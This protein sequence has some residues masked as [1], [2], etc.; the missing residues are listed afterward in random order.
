MNNS[1]I[2]NKILPLL[3]TSTI[4]DYHKEIVTI[5]LPI[6]QPTVLKGIYLAL[7]NEKKKMDK[8]E[9][10]KKLAELKYRVLSE[11]FEKI[12]KNKGKGLT[13]PK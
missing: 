11:K 9:K 8:L 5:L 1:T 6:M 12:Q 2:Q 7:F 13:K 3:K 4:S 10:E